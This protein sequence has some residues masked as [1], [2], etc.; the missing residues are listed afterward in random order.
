[1]ARNGCFWL[2]TNLFLAA[3]AVWGGFH[4]Y[5]SWQLVSS[6]GTAI[7]VVVALD[8]SSSDGSPVYS[9]VI[10]FTANGKT[11]SFEGGNASNPPAY[12]LGQKV[13]V[14]YDQSA[15]EKARVNSFFELWLFPLIII[16]IMVLTILIINIVYFIAILRG[17]RM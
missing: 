13:K 11:Y 1:M 2:L 6:G 12:H 15:P 3:F 4:A 10:E 8:E 16:P 9:P 7:G 14:L 5:S 17:R